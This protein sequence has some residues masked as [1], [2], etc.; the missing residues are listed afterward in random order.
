M[1]IQEASFACG[2]NYVKQ[3]FDLIFIQ[4]GMTPQ[5]TC[6][7]QIQVVFKKR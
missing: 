4:L 2:A 5:H 6:F 3:T 1:V 7:Y